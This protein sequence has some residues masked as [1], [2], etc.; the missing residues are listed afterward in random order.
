M[1][2]HPL[3]QFRTKLLAATIAAC[4]AGTAL[5]NPTLPQVVAGQAAFSQ[6]GNVFT[7]TNAP[8]TIINWHS[9]SI[10]RGEITRFLQQNADSRV[11]NRITGQD[12]SSILGALQSNGKVY[13]INPNGILFGKDARIDVN[14]LVASSLNITDAN[15]LA[16]KNL[17][18]GAGAAV[19]N[20]GTITTPQGGQVF[21]IA[22][23]VANTGIINAPNGEVLL[24]AGRSVQL[25][26][27]ADPAV[28]VVVSAP[29]DRA[30]NLG[31]IVAAGGRVGIYGA[32][33]NQRGT[34]N[35]DSAT[36]GANGK[37]VLKA[38]RTALIEGGSRTSA[39]GADKG[40]D[41]V[42]LGPQV[43]VTGDARID[44]GGAHG[45]GTVLLGGDKQGAATAAGA[46]A[47]QVYVGADATLA[48]DALVSGNG[49]KI[50][51]WGDDTARVHGT[52][53]V[54][55]AG[56][57]K[58]G[59]VET[60]GH[61]LDVN[62]VRVDA[63]G[64]GGNGSWL[65]DPY[66]I[67]VKAVVA[68]GAALSDVADF[69]AGS[70]S[71]VT[72]VATALLNNATANVKLQARHDIKISDA[73]NIAAAGV[74]LT[75]QA[76]NDIDVAASI[77]THG[78]AVDLSANDAA[79]GA[80]SGSGRVTIAAPLA[81]NGGDV[82]LAGARVVVSDDVDA[83]KA[84]V[85]LQSN[86][87]GGRI[88]IGSGA[89]VRASGDDAFAQQVSFVADDVK[90]DGRVEAGSGQG[91]FVSFTTTDAARG[92]LLG[93]DDSSKLSLGQAE[94]NRVEA[95]EINVGT[96]AHQ[97]G[98][99]V[100]GDVN[101][102]TASALFLESQG[103]IAIG[104]GLR[105]SASNGT[106]YVG[107][108]AASG[109]VT[110]S[111]GG[112]IEANRV[113]VRS[114]NVDIA[115]SIGAT[116]A[117]FDTYSDDAAIALG[118]SGGYLSAAE[119]AAVHAP[120]L[121]I[122]TR[123]GYAGTVTV[124]GALDLATAGAQVGDMAG[125]VTLQGGSVAVNAALK[126]H[127]GLTLRAT[128]AVTQTAALSADTLIASGASVTLTDAGNDVRNLAASATDAT[129]DIAFRTRG[130]LRLT[131]RRHRWRA[132]RSQ[133]GVGG[134][135]HRPGRQRLHRGRRA[136]RAGDRRRDPGHGGQRRALA[137]RAGWRR[138]ALR[139]RGRCGRGPPGRRRRRHRRHRRQGHQPRHRRRAGD[140][141]GNDRR[142][143]A[144][145]AHGRRR[146]LLR[147]GAAD[148]GGLAGHRERR[149]QRRCAHRHQE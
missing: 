56:T 116:Y 9:F 97:G 25:V 106:I 19:A 130:A 11:L 148:R 58:G 142:H 84:N 10:D 71:G 40:G 33:L 119:L 89:T 129:G 51:A 143:D 39:R 113:Q 103:N 55:G 124:A 5:A 137:G 117:A 73:V 120:R 60:S 53:S 63:S 14:G 141:R 134:G 59:F 100:V 52:V 37:I 61:Y 118:T 22:P 86:V 13:L 16:G 42:V 82:T 144:D 70:E 34:I 20:Q 30:L 90:L 104:A 81:T 99:A 91:G 3:P 105:A 78:G 87:A 85:L 36:V 32:L 149:H 1:N 74:G 77:T 110:V 24:A 98:I 83:G 92:I 65:L 140:V 133:R 93:G 88:E 72:Q 62:G 8:N 108:L 49:G 109:T 69:N 127:D 67:E 125:M 75:A 27:S 26:D 7:I 29:E 6:N 17:F 23:D 95:F 21:L 123:D 136:G 135:Q 45:G 4:F 50:V 35:A 107:N 57:G 79:A 38:S 121:A 68:G 46:N 145:R 48:A 64:A 132:G 139:R 44:A 80:A 15:F 147:A 138:G 47:R 128:G 146:R 28:H 115:G 101:L 126:A 18:D 41:I 31:A 43:G 131:G 114:N 12:P 2:Q 111:A 112:V 76:G 94:L 102:D 96:S 66:D 54:R 122:G